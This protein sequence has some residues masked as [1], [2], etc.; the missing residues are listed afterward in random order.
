MIVVVNLCF[1]GERDGPLHFV[2]SSKAPTPASRYGGYYSIYHPQ[3]YSGSITPLN[4]QSHPFEMMHLE[5]LREKLNR[6]SRDKADLDDPYG[7]LSKQRSTDM[8]E[9]RITPKASSEFPS[10]KSSTKLGDFG[11][12]N[13]VQE[14]TPTLPDNQPNLTLIQ[15]DI[16]EK[17]TPTQQ[18]VEQTV[19]TLDDIPPIRANQ[20]PVSERLIKSKII[21]EPARA[22]ANALKHAVVR[23]LKKTIIK[24]KSFDGNLPEQHIT[25]SHPPI[26]HS[27][28]QPS[29]ILIENHDQQLNE[30]S[31]DS[32]ESTSAITL[33]SPIKP[34]RLSDE[35][36][37]SSSIEVSS[38]PPAKPPRHFSLY[39]NDIDDN[40]IQETNDV[41][42]KVLNIVDTFDN[43]QQQNNNDTNILRQS[44]LNPNQSINCKVSDSLKNID[45]FS[46]QPISIAINTDLPLITKSFDNNIDKPMTIKSFSLST[47]QSNSLEKSINEIIPIEISQLAKEVTENILQ[48]VEK[49]TKVTNVDSTINNNQQILFDKLSQ[50]KQEQTNKKFCDNTPSVFHSKITTHILPT[51]TTSRPLVFVSL[52]SSS[53]PTKT[54]LPL[55]DIVTTKPTPLF[56]TS[57][58]VT[59]PSTSILSSTT[60]ITN[61]N[62]EL[63]NTSTLISNSNKTSNHTNVLQTNSKPDTVDSNDP[64]THDNTIFLPQNV[65]NTTSICSF[66]SDY[67][68]LRG[69][70]GSLNYDNQQTQILPSI[71]PSSSETMSSTASSSMTTIYQSFDNFPSLSLSSSATSPTYVSAVST[72]NTGGTTTP[73]H[74]GSDISDEELVESFDSENSPQASTPKIEIIEDNSEPIDECDMTFLT[75][76]LAQYNQSLHHQGLHNFGTT[77]VQSSFDREATLASKVEESPLS[78]LSSA[79]ESL[80]LLISVSSASSSTTFPSFPFHITTKTSSKFSSNMPNKTSNITFQNFNNISSTITNLNED[81]PINNNQ[82]EKKDSNINLQSPI[83]Q[84]RLPLPD[85]LT[86]EQN[87]TNLIEKESPLLQSE[88]LTT[89]H[90]LSV[91]RSR[92]AVNEGVTAVTGTILESLKGHFESNH[93]TDSTTSPI[94]K[95]KTNI[96]QHSLSIQT[97]PIT[98]KLP[99]LIEIHY[100]AE[101]PKS[102]Y[103]LVKAVNSFWIAQQIDDSEVEKRLKK[104]SS[105][106][107]K[108][109]AI[110]LP[111]AFHIDNYNSDDEEIFKEKLNEETL[112]S[113]IPKTPTNIDEEN[114]PNDLISE[115]NVSSTTVPHAQLGEMKKIHSSSLHQDNDQFEKFDD[116]IDEIYSIIDYLKHNKFT[117]TILNN[118]HMK[119]NDLKLLLHYIHLTK[120]D[121]LR[122]EYELD[123]L[124][125]SFNKT[126]KHDDYN[127]IELFE[128]NLRELQ[129]IVQEIKIFKSEAQENLITQFEPIKN[130]NGKDILNKPLVTSKTTYNRLIPENPVVTSDIFFE[131]NKILK[132]KK[133]SPTNPTRLIP[134]DARISASSFYEGDIH[135]SLYQHAEPEKQI[136]YT[137]KKKT[138]IPE[139]PYISFENFYEGDPQRSMFIERP[140]LIH[141]ESLSSSV[142]SPISIDNLRAI[143]S[144][145]MLVASWSKKPTK[146]IT[147]QTKPNVEV[148]AESFITTEKRHSKLCEITHDIERFPLS[149]PSILIEEQDTTLPEYIELHEE[150]IIE[151]SQMP[152]QEENLNDMIIIEKPLNEDQSNPISNDT[153]FIIVSSPSFKEDYEQQ[154][155]IKPYPSDHVESNIDENILMSSPVI[156]ISTGQIENDSFNNEQEDI[157]EENLHGFQSVPFYNE[158]YRKLSN[159]PVTSHVQ[160]SNIISKTITSYHD[161]EERQEEEDI[162]ESNFRPTHLDIYFEEQIQYENLLIETSNNLV[163]HILNEAISEL[164]EYEQNYLYYQA[165][166]QIVNDVIENIIRNY[167]NEFNLI[168]STSISSSSTSSDN[169]IKEENDEY[170]DEYLSSSDDEENEKLIPQISDQPYLFVSDVITSKSTQELGN[171]IQELQTLEHKIDHI[172]SLSSSSS[173]SSSSLS[174]NDQIQSYDISIPQVVKTKSINELTNLVTELEHIEEELEDKLDE[175]LNIDKSPISS[176]SFNELGGLI[177]ELNDVS[178]QLNNRIHEEIFTST[179]IESLSQDIVKYRRDSQSNG[180]IPN[181][182]KKEQQSLNSTIYEQDF[183]SIKP[184]LTNGV[185]QIYD[186]LQKEQIENQVVKVL[187]DNILKEALAIMLFELSSNVSQTIAKSVPTIIVDEYPKPCHKSSV[188]SISDDLEIS[189]EEYA[190]DRTI[191]LA[192]QLDYLQRMSRY[193]KLTNEQE[194]IENS[195]ITQEDSFIH[196]NS[197]DDDEEFKSTNDLSITHEKHPS[198]N[199]NNLDKLLIQAEEQSQTNIIH[200]SMIRSKDSIN[201]HS[202]DS[203]D[204]HS[205]EIEPNQSSTQRTT[206]ENSLHSASS[207]HTYDSHSLS[208]SYLIDN[209]DN[210]QENLFDYVKSFINKQVE[211]VHETIEDQIKQR[212]SQSNIND[213]QRIDNSEKEFLTIQQHFQSAYDLHDEEK[214]KLV[215]SPELYNMKYAIKHNHRALL[216]NSQI[217]H[218][219]LSESALITDDSKHQNLSTS[220]QVSSEFL[221]TISKDNSL[222]SMQQQQRIST[223]FDDVIEKESS[224]EHSESYNIPISAFSDALE[225][226]SSCQRPL[227][228]CL[229]QQQQIITEAD[230]HRVAN[231]LVNQVLQNVITEL[232]SEQDDTSTSNKSDKLSSSSTSSDNDDEL[233][234]QDDDNIQNLLSNSSNLKTFPHVSF[235][236]V[237]RRAQTDT[238]HFEIIQSPNARI[239]SLIRRN[240]QSDTET[241]FRTISSSIDNST[242]IKA[243]YDNSSSDEKS[244]NKNSTL[245]IHQNEKYSGEGE[246]SS[247]GP[248][249]NIQRRKRSN[250]T[251]NINESPGVKILPFKYEF[252]DNFKRQDSL[253]S[254][255]KDSNDKLI[256]KILHEGILRTNLKSFETDV[257]FMNQQE[258]NVHEQIY[259]STTKKLSPYYDYDAGSEAERDDLKICSSKHSEFVLPTFP[260]E[261]NYN[262]LQNFKSGSRPII[263]VSSSIELNEISSSIDIDIKNLLDDL[264][265]SI[266]DGL[267]ISISSEPLSSQ[268]DATTVIFNSNKNSMD[269]E[270]NLEKYSFVSSHDLHQNDKQCLTIPISSSSS[271]SS[272]TQSVIYYQQDRSAKIRN[273]LTSFVNTNPKKQSSIPSFS[274]MQLISHNTK[275]KFRSYPGSL[276]GAHIPPSI[277]SILNDYCS[278]TTTS[279]TFKSSN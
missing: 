150:Q 263:N 40:V 184:T 127:F 125:N 180:T 154:L 95:Y 118:L 29:S 51:Q 259:S 187:V 28:S 140:L 236:K 194:K 233:C 143:M 115:E 222:E 158:D 182:H 72:F 200:D 12:V 100:D 199:E 123:E 78:S 104:F 269:D 254:P 256:L 146:I 226:T 42:K 120:Q 190:V 153:E 94:D 47:K 53:N 193:E 75:E 101:S 69:S 3:N 178:K 277:E 139:K 91:F 117:L 151:S 232:T 89:E 86:F 135:R 108:R 70:N 68:N 264:I 168:E 14:V 58:T 152:E 216:T 242:Q 49:Q 38:P 164:I 189:H 6:L 209:K 48:E 212:T 185:D 9:G 163:E 74:L 37:S 179:N 52:S 258:E 229:S 121:E 5:S 128:Q 13:I 98:E 113:L 23:P 237:L 165:A 219:T 21:P 10:K 31:I 271:S 45:T 90:E 149:H 214:S 41:V 252:N 148:H 198:S 110:K 92:L 57:V 220:N 205:T 183:E 188:T 191:E 204:Y 96:L 99:E 43:I 147:Q 73:Q 235:G 65:G 79:S 260:N 145:L 138:L 155:I 83:H 131:R 80:S 223:P 133:I 167:D 250:D 33:I 156:E 76:V 272:P 66:L 60:T 11:I 246:E 55:L 26:V 32:N 4:Y 130:T 253:E 134:E 35:S 82:Q 142:S 195:P 93:K 171:L 71:I 192:A 265:E 172:H 54:N 34:P 8:D 17:P 238:E 160:R 276:G 174:D 175:P 109:A 230:Y 228:F 206:S 221:T 50:L 24:K 20:P 202:T 169:E 162:E 19:Q 126:S 215:R 22:L 218:R 274:N 141:A 102:P 157:N 210:N 231:D 88:L 116:K 270:E 247:A 275:T 61:T 87:I 144:D 64:T 46:V 170:N 249:R 15:S 197:N 207:I 248:K 56:T 124:E 77:N 119:L 186:Q 267:P 225:P 181:A 107:M 103:I 16:N 97:S 25:R 136:D 234:E 161:E 36:G 18:L 105:P 261:F 268:S 262:N 255:S 211:I 159:S 85:K 67:D 208:T 251:M 62:E 243:P 266:N 122:I 1:K 129:Y 227:A 63:N 81:N 106:V 201:Q 244:T 39:K 44:L 166:V 245:S 278:T 224:P 59:S 2:D 257:D 240:S 213:N 84:R 30:I 7:T 273:N 112:S 241:Y 176:K 279:T 173:S 27:L 217:Q 203:L 111:D 137:N 239:P 177:N 114:K 196:T 132:Q